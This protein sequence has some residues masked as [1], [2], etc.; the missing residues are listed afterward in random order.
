VGERPCWLLP[1]EGL[2]IFWQQRSRATGFYQFIR[3]LFLLWYSYWLRNIL[4]FQYNFS[5]L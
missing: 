5:L 3:N 1:L 2:H 4:H